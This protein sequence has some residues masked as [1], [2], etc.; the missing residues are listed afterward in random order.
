[1]GCSSSI[2]PHS[3][4]I[5]MRLLMNPADSG[6][7]TQPRQIHQSFSHFRG[8][9]IGT[10][11]QACQKLQIQGLSSYIAKAKSYSINPKKGLKRDEQAAIN[12]YTQQTQFYKQLN[13]ALRK[14]DERTLMQWHG[15]LKLFLAALDKLPPHQGTVW[16]GVPKDLSAKYQENSE[17]VWWPFSSCTSSVRVLESPNFLGTSGARTLFNVETFDGRLISEFSEYATEDEIL[18]LSGTRIRVVSVLKQ[19]GGLTIIHVKQIKPSYSLF[20]SSESYVEAYNPVSHY[21]HHN[22]PIDEPYSQSYSPADEYVPDEQYNQPP[23]KFPV[24]EKQC[25][26][27]TRV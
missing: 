5:N 19:P 26:T 1:M 25:L 4:G 21:R 2:P 6:N 12:L 27:F 11:E 13:D 22:A 24:T 14:N 16:R 23:S 9:P 3:G 15:Y 8:A 7:N 20:G 10:L 18:L 17:H